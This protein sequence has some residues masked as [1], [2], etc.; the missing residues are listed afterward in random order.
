MDAAR[1]T[2]PVAIPP[3]QSVLAHLRERLPLAEESLLDLLARGGVV[4]PDGRVVAADEPAKPGGTLFVERDL[5]PEPRVPL[6][7]P[8]LFRDERVVVVDK[9]PF[10]AVTPRG[11]HAAETVVARLRMELDLP[12]LTAAH[13]LDR[14]TSGVLLLTTE[15]RWRRPYQELFAR[16]AV[17]KR[18]RAVAPLLPD[19]VVPHRIRDH[20]AKERGELRAHVVAGAPPNAET[21]IEAVEVMEAVGAVEALEGDRA[22]YSLRPVTGRTHQ[23][24]V[25]LA[26][27]GAPIDGDP[28]YPILRPEAPPLVTDEGQVVDVRDPLQLLAAELSFVDPVSAKSLRFASPRGL[29]LRPCDTMRR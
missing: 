12:E 24:R 10:L 13:R 20:L 29:P 17:T 15:R 22:V 16:G 23:L 8:I 19:L 9:P 5:Q 21:V 25:H 3:G 1:L 14:L 7:I 2:I 26:G 18:Y 6:P 11:Q 28:L 4:A 27:L